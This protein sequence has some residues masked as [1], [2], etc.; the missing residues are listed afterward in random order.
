M[1]RPCDLLV[2]GGTILDLDAPTGVAAADT[3]VVVG[4][5][6][7]AVGQ[8]ADMADVWEPG[9]TIDARGHYVAPGFVDGHVHLAAYLGAAAPYQP[10]RGPGLFSGAT[11]TQEILP[12][13][14]QMCRAPVSDEVVAAI[15]RPVYAALARAGCT[16]V[17]DAGSAGHRGL[18]QAAHEV[19]VRAAIGPT[20]ADT[21]HDERGRLLRWDTPLA[22][23][24]AAESVASDIDGAGGGLVRS[25]VSAIE[26]MAC[27]D[28]LLRGLADLVERL[29]LP[30]HVHTHI[31]PPSVEEHCRTRGVSPT[32]TLLDAGLLTP[33]CT[34][35]HVG[36][37]TEDDIETFAAC[38]VTANHNPLGNAML[39]FGTAH[40]RSLPR[41]LAASVPVLLGSDYAPSMM[42]TPF[43][44]IRACLIVHREAAA[45]DDAITLEQ[46]LSMS[47]DTGTAL[48]HPGRL[49]RIEPGRLADLICVRRNGAHH[50]GVTHPVPG[51]AL[52]ARAADVTTTIV[53]GR[54]VV[55]DGRLASVDEAEVVAEAE[56][57]LAHL[58]GGP[59][60]AASH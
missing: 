9:E 19:G 53:G 32:A 24:E 51:L 4:D 59:P 17:V 42:A 56:R 7:A 33:R 31:S 55:R 58:R 12:R 52:R 34:V 21:W 41:L 3:V 47:L 54:I 49:G 48:G 5:E 45:A 40:A 13:I 57:A 16:G 38:G 39:G 22:V 36:A 11:R 30:T 28:E 2:S 23:L 25:V 15:T 60:A 27:S 1:R 29:D 43:D 35:M 37:L 44:L 50:V 6:I 46:A 20:V 8:A 10:A 26:T 14:V 18:A